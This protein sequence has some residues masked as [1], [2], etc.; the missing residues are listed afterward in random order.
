MFIKPKEPSEDL[1]I[2]F[3]GTTINHQSTIK[4]L[5]IT[6][7]SDLKY[8]SHL[9]KGVNNMT[10]SIRFKSTLLKAAKPFLPIK[11][12]A[13]VGNNLVNS[14]IAYGAPLWGTSTCKNI[15][16]VQA[17][18]TK[19]ARIITGTTWGEEKFTHRQE[20]LTRLAWPN[21]RQILLMASTSLARKAGL[22][23]TSNG[24]NTMISKITPKSDRK[25][26]SMRLKHLGPIKRQSDIFSA[27]ATQQ[28]NGLPI[29]LRSPQLTSGQ[30]KTKIKEFAM[31]SLHLP[32]HQ[33][34]THISETNKIKKK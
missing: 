13:T 27:N 28:F 31:S 19:V 12:L 18:Q 3:N 2:Q 21:V 5:G 11:A 9:Q 1:N 14:T 15:D 4:I 8:D 23:Q 26:P 17:A 24:L 7:A 34:S 30:F 20:I 25:G 22:N 32:E 29:E 10:K 33:S 16:R 6:L